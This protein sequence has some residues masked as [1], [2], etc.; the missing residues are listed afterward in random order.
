[1]EHSYLNEPNKACTVN[2]PGLDPKGTWSRGAMIIALCSVFATVT[3]TS[4]TSPPRPINQSVV[5]TPVCEV[6]IPV[7]Y[8]KLKHR[9]M[10]FSIDVN[11]INY[12][13]HV[14]FKYLYVKV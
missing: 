9:H 8:V 14:K 13:Y 6:K 5:L 1:M 11:E 2:T 4:V 10:K 7:A 3:T 12:L